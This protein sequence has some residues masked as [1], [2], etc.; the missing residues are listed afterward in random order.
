MKQRLS[1]GLKIC[2]NYVFWKTHF[3]FKDT[4]RLKEKLLKKYIPLT[5]STHRK[6]GV[7]ILIPD[8]KG[9]K[10]KTTKCFYI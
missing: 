5:N 3:A 8:K 4:N 10:T 7:A 2:S 6:T 1:G 9:I